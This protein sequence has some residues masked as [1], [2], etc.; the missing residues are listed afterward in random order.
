L[1]AEGRSA[2]SLREKPQISRP[3]VGTPP[4]RGAAMSMTTILIGAV[5]AAI[6][7]LV[8][9]LLRPGVTFALGGRVFAFMAVAVVPIL[10]GFLGLGEHME[11]SKTTEF[12]LS[13]HPMEKYGRSLHVDDINFLPAAHYQFGRVP[14]ETACFSCHTN[15][16]MFGDY[17]AKLNGLHHVYV[18][19]LGKVPDAIKLYDKYNNRECLHCHGEAR[20][21]LEAVTHKSEPGRLD[22]IYANRL[23]CLTKGCHDTTHAVDKLDTA[24]FWPP[25]PVKQAVNEV[26][27]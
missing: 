5:V 18:Q 11:R 25:E 17:K 20:G 24:T 26:N 12:C 27:K 3:I 8:P 22:A 16:T 9:L 19:Y 2:Q 4:A 7:L 15:Y 21:F 6:A 13:C 10:A 1:R 14:R 23:S